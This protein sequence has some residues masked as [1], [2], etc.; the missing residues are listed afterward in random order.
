MNI[1]HKNINF[2]G[3][4]KLYIYIETCDEYEFGKEFL[5]PDNPENFF[6]K[7]KNY[8]KNIL[9]S[10]DEDVAVLIV[11]GVLIG[12]I[13]L[14]V[15]LNSSDQKVKQ[16][17]EE[18]T[19]NNYIVAANYIKQ[20]ENEKNKENEIQKDI[21]VIEENNKSPEILENIKTSVNKPNNP[22]INKPAPKPNNPVIN[23]P[24]PTE[25]TIQLKT[26]GTVIT[27]NLEDYVI[28][29]V[30]AE[31]PASFS[32]EALKAQAVAARTFALKKKSEGSILINSTAHQVYKTKAQMQ[33]MWGGSYSTYYNKIK[34]AAYSTKGITMK[35]NGSY[36]D[37]FYHAI[38]NTKTELPSYV[39]GNNK[40]YLKS[41]SSNWD[42]NVRGFKVST[43]ISYT[44]LSSKLGINVNSSTEF[45]VLS[46]TISGRVE[47]IKIGNKTYSGVKLRSLLGLRSADFEIKKNANNVTVTT[48]GYGHGV[49]MSQY[50]ANEAAK[51]GY[52]YIKILKHYYSGIN[53][54]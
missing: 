39:W 32:S 15:F 43:N 11:N 4:S 44:T 37:A 38:S 54:S 51:E 10:K 16:E 33:S 35:Y 5:S 8:V 21:S 46:E 1:N 28:G 13:S 14:G 25:T 19:K 24:V 52:N 50:G 40:P 27:L 20:N 47:N 41:V 22:V 42:S 49:G 53:I 9:K 3:E 48:K 12:A 17:V 7:I 30:A 2:N 26:G 23:K 36:I 31:M 45:K 18:N 29:V 6:S 34:N